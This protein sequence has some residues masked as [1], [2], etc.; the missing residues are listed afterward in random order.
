MSF[1]RL[2]KF[3]LLLSVMSSCTSTYL[4]KDAYGA[5][6]FVLDS[7]KIRE[8]KLSVLDLCGIDVQQDEDLFEEEGSSAFKGIVD[9]IGQV[10]NTQVNIDGKMRLFDV[11]SKAEL[12][13]SANLLKSYIIRNNEMIYVDFQKLIFE[14]DFSQNII[15][16]GGDKI[17]IAHADDSSISISG[18]VKNPK[19]I[20][21]KDRFISLSEALA[22]AGGISYKGDFS[23]IQIIRGACLKPKI[24]KVNWQHVVY[25]P[26]DSML[27]MPGDLVYVPPTSITCWHRFISQLI[28]SI[29]N[30]N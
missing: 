30:V 18:E 24:Y 28:P 23:Q 12:T 4:G 22:Q 29:A 26:Q 7:Y 25:L 13:Q 16:K 2:M 14:G 5:D 1:L 27:L 9:L 10:K 6:E 17:F 20:C 3:I 21:V 19:T 8:G 15:L 11:L